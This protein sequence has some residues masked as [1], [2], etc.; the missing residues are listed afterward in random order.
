M[1]LRFWGVRGSLPS[2]PA[3]PEIK[4]K[5][6]EALL[7]AWETIPFPDAEKLSDFADSL[8]PTFANFVGGNTPCLEIS[9]GDRMMIFDA[10]S[11]IK[12]LGDYLLREREADP[13]GAK[14]GVGSG[15]ETDL[16]SGDGEPKPEDPRPDPRPDP[17]HKG[18]LSLFLTH[19][20]W[21]HIQGFPFFAPIYDPETRLT[22]HAA[23]PV[24][25]EGSL[26]IQQSTR[27]LFPMLFD[28]LG[29]EIT[30]KPV[31]PGGVSLPPFLVD[32]MALPHPGGCSAY[33]IKAFGHTIVFATDYELSDDSRET[34]AAKEELSRFVANCDVFVSDTQYTY[35]ES[36]SK[37]G[38]GH[39]NA[40]NVVD[41]A[42]MSGVK[43]LYLFHHDPGYPDSKLHSM[44]EKARNYN[45]L[46][47]PKGSLDIHLASEGLTVEFKTLEKSEPARGES[48]GETPRDPGG[49]SRKDARGK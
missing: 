17:R 22:I 15:N 1:R 14:A 49:N 32:S 10:G 30:F 2:P 43:N 6:K 29:A 9:H 28:E 46:L 42:Q 27:L 7:R 34:L 45:R 33:R 31:P 16:G 21:D 38:W 18:D 19:T 26:R 11:G 39:S 4:D 41:M 13:R 24:A 12:H 5:I 3:F 35:L 20:H 47:F 36:H 48:G 25:V 8:P 37:E 40:L 44:L 23:D